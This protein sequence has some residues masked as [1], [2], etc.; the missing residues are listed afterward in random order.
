MPGSHLAQLIESCLPLDPTSRAVALE[1]DAE[2]DSVYHQVALQGQS[3][4]PANP[5]DEVDF[6]YVCFVKSH[7]DNHL[8]LLDGDRKGPVDCGVFSG[9][10]ILSKAGL[11]IIK[12]FISRV[13]RGLGFSLLALGPSASNDGS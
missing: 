9:E 5:E 6:H 13:A 10:D 2:L 11:E 4:V 12:A 3:E 1:N 7:K 8:Y